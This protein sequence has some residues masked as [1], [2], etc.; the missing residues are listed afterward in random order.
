MSEYIDIFAPHP[1]L[2][3]GVT[4]RREGTCTVLDLD[5]DAHATVIVEQAI[6]SAT[7]DA[8]LLVNLAQDSTIDLTV[9]GLGENNADIDIQVHLNGAGAGAELRGVVVSG[10]KQQVDITTRVFHHAE[11][12]V[13]NQLFKYIAGG[14]SRCSFDG[15]IV[16]EEQA[17]FTEAFQTNRNLLASEQAQMHAQP[18]L[19]IYCDE[20]K[21]SHGAATGQ[22]D[23]QALFYMRQ[24]GIPLA[25]ARAMLM[26]AFVADVIDAIPAESIREKAHEQVCNMM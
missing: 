4:L 6:Q 25:E 13:S 3:R 12:T 10:Q 2:P 14:E 20:V 23:E 17:R 26:Q 24:R 7:T 9:L 15:K 22:F 5:H 16:V 18:A 1:I 11:H 8:Q 21:C 19:E